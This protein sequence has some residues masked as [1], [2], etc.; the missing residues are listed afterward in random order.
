MLS[1]SPL[2]GPGLFGAG[3][4]RQTSST[5]CQRPLS[6][7]HK[8][9]PARNTAGLDRQDPRHL[10]IVA[11]SQK[12]FLVIWNITSQGSCSIAG[13]C[14]NL[15]IGH[16][17]SD[18]QLSNFTMQMPCF[19]PDDHSILFRK[20]ALAVPHVSMHST[21]DP[22]EITCVEI[23]LCMYGCQ[24]T[25]LQRPTRQALVGEAHSM[26]V[27]N[28]RRMECHPGTAPIVARGYTDT[29]EMTWNVLGTHGG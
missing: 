7:T 19:A 29:P 23:V 26:N 2:M 9:G 15:T 13:V 11:H 27:Q 12:P 6:G 22:G 20:V 21:D 5:C 18:F 3:M 24:S 16:L 14:L 10:L 25:P 4:K 8:N 17:P 28:T 1:Q